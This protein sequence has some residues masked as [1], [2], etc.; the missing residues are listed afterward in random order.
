MHLPSKC[1]PNVRGTS[2]LHQNAAGRDS[3]PAMTI[4]VNLSW[5][6]LAQ[7]LMQHLILML[8]NQIRSMADHL[9]L[10]LSLHPLPTV[11]LK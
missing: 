1:I 5:Q 8:A 2:K 6:L 11:V 3:R 9:W 7:I 4:L 10:R